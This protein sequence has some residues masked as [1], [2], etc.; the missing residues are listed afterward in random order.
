MTIRRKPQSEP[1]WVTCPDCGQHLQAEWVDV[2]HGLDDAYGA[3]VADVDW[4]LVTTCAC[5]IPLD[6]ALAG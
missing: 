2:G 5:M 4:Q 6:P 3:P 1:P